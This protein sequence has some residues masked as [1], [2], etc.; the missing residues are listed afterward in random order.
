[1]VIRPKFGLSKVDI[2][3]IQLILRCHQ[4]QHLRTIIGY[5]EYQVAVGADILQFR[6]THQYYKT[7]KY[8]LHR[9]IGD[10]DTP[11]A[12]FIKLII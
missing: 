8:E 10:E 4:L 12:I 11:H 7:A 6:S 5:L 3:Q 9:T 1:M 2:P